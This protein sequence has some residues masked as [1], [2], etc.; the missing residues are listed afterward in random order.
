MGALSSVLEGGAFSSAPLDSASLQIHCIDPRQSCFVFR[1]KRETAPR[2]VLRVP[3]EP[4]HHRIRV[5][6]LQFFL[7]LL[8]TVHVEIVK[9]RLPVTCPLA[10]RRESCDRRMKKAFSKGLARTSWNGTSSSI[11]AGRTSQQYRAF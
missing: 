7:S 1:V 8:V 3:H 4:S 10:P 9:P 5:H 11:C 2:P 6:V